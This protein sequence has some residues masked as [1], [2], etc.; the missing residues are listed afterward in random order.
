MVPMVV[1]HT[2]LY[3]SEEFMKLCRSMDFKSQIESIQWLPSSF[4]TLCILSHFT[5]CQSLQPKIKI[6]ACF[7]FSTVQHSITRY[8][9]SAAGVIQRYHLHHCL[10]CQVHMM[11]YTG[12]RVQVTVS[13]S[14]C[15][16]VKDKN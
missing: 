16:T 14:P 6:K 12:A 13:A 4:F 5:N 2:P 8:H 7:I 11:A 3:F 15:C 1:Y 9:M 10:E